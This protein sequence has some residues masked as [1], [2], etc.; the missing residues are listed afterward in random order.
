MKRI[1][2]GLG[3]CGI[4]AGGTKVKEVLETLIKENKIDVSLGETGCMG[5]C[6][7]NP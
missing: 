5:I 6:Y 7:K 3:S 4:A 2:V 1:I